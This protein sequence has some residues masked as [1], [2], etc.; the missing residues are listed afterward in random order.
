M[1]LNEEQKQLNTL[2]N[3]IERDDN[4]KSTVVLKL[5]FKND[6]NSLKTETRLNHV[7]SNCHDLYKYT[8]CSYS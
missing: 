8:H 1:A 2:S 3:L 7:F 4:P 5:I 6:F